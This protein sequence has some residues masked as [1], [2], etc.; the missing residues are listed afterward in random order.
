MLRVFVLAAGGLALFGPAVGQEPDSSF[1]AQIARPAYSSGSGPV[2]CID[3]AHANAHTAAGRY[4]PF[5]QLVRDDGYR[6]TE[7]LDPWTN[8][9]LG[10]CSV[11]VV[12]NAL[13]ESNRQ[14]RSF[15][16]PSAFSRDEIDV[17]TAWIDAGG[18]LLLIADHSPWAGA[19]R[20]LGLVLGF[21]MLDAFAAPSDSGAVIA[22]FGSAAVPDTAWR[23]YATERNL[24]VSRIRTAVEAPGTL[25]RHPILAGRGEDERIR[26]VITY[27]GHAIHPSRRVE[28][29][30]IFGPEAVAAVDRPDASLIPV[31]GWLQAGAAQFG[32]GRVVVLGEAAACTAQVGG[33]RRIRTGMNTS[34]APH[35]AQFCLNVI[36]WLS[37][38]LPSEGVESKLE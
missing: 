26:W 1:R 25:G 6:V 22:V 28:P 5:A 9:E 31:P 19:A 12:A 8:S 30:L 7:V 16:H 13:S 23:R 37:G 4:W 11:L 36:H 24:L 3:A 35:N 17:I 32:S 2:V 10:A 18:G 15:P 33:P 29:L 27:T 38:L 21:E 20:D 34:I 14:D